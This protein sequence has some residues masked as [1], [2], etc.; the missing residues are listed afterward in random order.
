MEIVGRLVRPPIPIENSRV[1]VPL[2][3]TELRADFKQ[4]VIHLRHLPGKPSC[5]IT[6]VKKSQL[7]ESKAL[8]KSTLKRRRLQQME[9]SGGF[10]L[11]ERTKVRK[12]TTNNDRNA[13]DMTKN[14]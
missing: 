5:S 8:L 7:N 12:N 1:G 6:I 4:P 9:R 13:N 2:T 11:R 10:A 3:K 14:E